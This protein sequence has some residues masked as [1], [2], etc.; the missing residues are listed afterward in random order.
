MGDLL[1]DLNHD[2]RTQEGIMVEATFVGSDLV[3]VSLRP[4]V[5]VD[6]SQLN[7][8]AASGG[9]DRLLRKIQTASHRLGAP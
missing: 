7:L 9:G 2:E 4:T 8:L 1:F 3:Q 6:N 5:V